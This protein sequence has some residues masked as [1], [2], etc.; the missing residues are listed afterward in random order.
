MTG[1]LFIILC[2]GVL[3]LPMLGALIARLLG[4]RYGQRSLQTAGMI[5]FGSALLCALVV[6]SVD[7][8]R[9][10]L[11]TFAIF[12]PRSG[13][14]IDTDAFTLRRQPL[15][16]VAG[17]ALETP[18]SSAEL[19]AAVPPMLPPTDALVLP[20]QVPPTAT[21]E[22]PTEP[23]PEPTLEPTLEPTAEPTPEPTLEPTAEPTPEPTAEPTPEPTLEPTAEAPPPEPTAVPPTAVRPTAVAQGSNAIAYTVASGDTLRGIAERFKISVDALLKYNG[24]TRAQGD[25][26]SIGQ[27]LYIP[28]TTSSAPAAPAATRTPQRATQAYVVKSGDTL[29]SIAARFNI[30]V[31]ALLQFN[32][33]TRTEGDKL[34]IG[35]KLYIPAR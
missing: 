6:G 16:D 19:V 11:G 9:L 30:T 22:P 5:G 3:L 14:V 21:L 32:G 17:G 4:A 34:Q 31:D 23:T 28:R 7:T 2:M 13:P 35:Q 8:E 33:L 12:V 1:Q 20:T 15:A 29:R 25:S 26:L 18:E 10:E 24:L 27:R